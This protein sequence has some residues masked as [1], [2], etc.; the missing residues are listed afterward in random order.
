MITKKGFSL[1]EV[2]ITLGIIGVVA[3]LC[4]PVLNSSIQNN[5]NKTKFRKAMNSLSSAISSNVVEDNY[6]FSN[7]D[8]G[9]TGADDMSIY[10]IFFNHLNVMK[11]NHSGAQYT[12]TFQDGSTVT[13]SDSAKEC[14]ESSPCRATIDVNGPGNPNILVSCDTGTCDKVTKTAD[15]FP[16]KLYDDQVVPDSQAARAVF[17]NK[18]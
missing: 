13:F 18:K 1:P 12:L 17:Y 8:S 11:V 3:A 10:N 14:T 7:T 2:L 6:D 4:M 9:G 16:V 5:H 15:K